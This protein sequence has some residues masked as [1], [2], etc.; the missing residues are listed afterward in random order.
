MKQLGNLVFILFIGGLLTG[1]CDR[2]QVYDSFSKIEDG[3]WGWD[4]PVIFEAG[5]DDTLQNHDILIQLRHTTS[6]PLSNLYMFVHVDGPS[7]QRMTDTINFILARK[8]GEWIGKGVGHLKEIGYLYKREARFP[9]S[10]IYRFT[11][12][13]AMR[14][15]EVPVTEV[16]LRIKPSNS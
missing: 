5:I 4:E 15:E 6:Y 10:G 11:I 2:D 3:N 8:S 9:E 14:L 16:G 7:G 13:Q 1:S 12:E